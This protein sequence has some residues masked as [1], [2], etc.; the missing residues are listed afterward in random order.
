MPL[1][2]TR[3]AAPL[4]LIERLDRRENLV[5]ARVVNVDGKR[6]LITVNGGNR[7]LQEQFR[8]LRMEN[9][10]LEYSGRRW[11]C[12]NFCRGIRKTV[13]QIIA[14]SK[15]YDGPASFLNG[16]PVRFSGGVL[17]FWEI[18]GYLSKC[19]YRISRCKFLSDMSGV[20]RLSRSSSP[21]ATL[22][23]PSVISRLQN[24]NMATT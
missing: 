23:I 8:Q 17:N 18:G 2:H 11:K 10:H 5:M 6:S 24:G 15:M 19:I 14:R 20:K 9:S 16:R 3:T 1:T 21:S 22:S 7:S 12:S 4:S 13:Y